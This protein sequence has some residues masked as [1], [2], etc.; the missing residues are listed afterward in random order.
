[1]QIQQERSFY[2]IGL[3]ARTS[4]AAELAG[5]GVIGKVW[6][7]FFSRSLLSR[8][9]HRIDEAIVA[10]YCDYEKD[11]NGAYTFMLGA[12]VQRIDEVPDEM[13]AY[14][15]PE[16]TYTIF[17]SKQGKMPNVEVALWQE[18]WAAEDAGILK[19]AYIAD[20]VVYDERAH[21]PANAVVE[22][23]IGIKK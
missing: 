10:V 16:Q 20:Y 22:I 11:K 18:I 14:K 9:S 21:D 8:I 2:I 6:H 12:R 4:N 7:H 5:N 13:T 19:R 17:T 3:A 15:L 23:H 1:M